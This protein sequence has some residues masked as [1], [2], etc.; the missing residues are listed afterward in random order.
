[1]ADV[2]GCPC[3][4]RLTRSCFGNVKIEGVPCPNCCTICREMDKNMVSVAANDIQ[5]S[6]LFARWKKHV[7]EYH[8]EGGSKPRSGNG[9][10]Q[11]AFAFT[12]TM[13]PQHGYTEADMIAAA[14]KVM[15][16][17][18]CPVKKY[19]WYLE[20]RD[21]E[22]K[23][24][25]HIHG[26]YETEKGG[27]IERKHWVRAW[28]IWGE[29]DPNKRLGQGFVGGYH[30]PVELDECYEQYIQKQQTEDEDAPICETRGI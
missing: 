30:R 22:N 17:T 16:Q 20:Y 13:S 4:L 23:T 27:R 1:M 28:P 26:M 19:A 10:Y 7:R 11:G 29:G 3:P 14:R 15:N 6:V 25:A 9:K 12:L 21:I 24:G 5:L 8:G 18:S 2:S